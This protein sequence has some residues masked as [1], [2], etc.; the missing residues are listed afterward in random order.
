LWKVLLL[1]E[2]VKSLYGKEITGG[3]AGFARSIY[4]L[5]LQ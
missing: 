5:G 3:K 1:K 4:F 2:T